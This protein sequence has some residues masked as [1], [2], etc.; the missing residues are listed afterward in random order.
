MDLKKLLRPHLLHLHPYSSAR[1]EFSGEARIFLDANENAFGSSAEA[2]YNRY[3]DPY[4]SKLKQGISRL[5]NISQE[6][7]FL[8]NG[9]DEPIDLL[10]RAF[11]SPGRD[12]ILTMP[13]T[14]GMYQVCA[15]IN[16]VKNREVPLTMDFQIDLPAVIDH[17]DEEVK[18]VFIC[19]PNNP[20]G[21]NLRT[22]DVKTIVE[23]CKGLVVVD[24][25]YTDFCPHVS[26]T[27]IQSHYQNLVVLQTLSKAWGLAGLRLGMMFAEPDLVAVMNKIKPP[28]NISAPAQQ[29]A[30]K[31]LGNRELVLDRIEKILEQRQ[32]LAKRLPGCRIVKKVYP[33]DANFLLVQV[34]HPLEVYHRLLELGIV[35]R[36]RS[37]LT[38]CAGCLRITVGTPEEN[39]HLLDALGAM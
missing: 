29:I 24:E 20:T 25:A 33:S 13:P 1:D 39:A 30:I 11:C 12:A 18:L 22:E 17:L 16:G 15:E 38:L 31:A 7:I 14:Y 28:Y 21:N 2:P 3:P 6:R 10:I 8:G 27:G 9:S 23:H 36:D 19:N 4:Q 26:L 34:E 32:A 37:R 35:V 5:K